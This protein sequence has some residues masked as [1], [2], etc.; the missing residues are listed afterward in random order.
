M[1]TKRNIVNIVENKAILDLAHKHAAA[2]FGS[3]D[4]KLL[5]LGIKGSTSY[6]LSNSDS[7]TD[8]MGIILPPVEYILGTK[9]FEQYTFSDVDN[10]VEGIVY[11]FQKFFKLLLNQNPNILE[12]L[13]LNEYVYADTLFIH[14]L[15]NNRNHFLSTKIKHTYAGY[16]HEQLSRLD[17]LNRKT[18]QNTKRKNDVEKYGYSTKN[19]MHLIRLLKVAIYALQTGTIFVLLPDD[20]IKMLMKIRNGKIAYDKVVELANELFNE[21]EDIYKNSPLQTEIDAEDACKLQE[22]VLFTYIHDFDR[23][24]RY[25]ILQDELSV[26]LT[27]NA[28]RLDIRNLVVGQTIPRI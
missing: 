12:L 13:W 8:V 27:S 22:T 25:D 23:G 18:N 2:V 10:K 5:C 4:Y 20:D 21:V 16:A 7:D 1:E 28:Y 26:G 14:A 3:T 24:G 11:S 6:G 19:A 9:K 17:K 15:L